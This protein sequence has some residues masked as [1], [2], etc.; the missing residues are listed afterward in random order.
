MSIL[1]LRVTIEDIEPAVLRCIEVCTAMRLDRLHLVLQAAMPWQNYY[2]WE[3]HNDNTRWG[4]PDPDYGDD[5]HPAAKVTL[6]DVALAADGS[7][8]GYLY[9]FGD[10]WQHRIVVED[11]I[12][13]APR[14]LYPRPHRRRGPVPARERRRL[15]RI[16]ALSR[17]PSDPEHTDI[18]EW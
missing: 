7:A 5:V 9:D 14:H 10:S 15:P 2:L 12:E 18:L 11:R 17:N 4:L 13:P 1:R 8:I 3:F 16:R 6:G